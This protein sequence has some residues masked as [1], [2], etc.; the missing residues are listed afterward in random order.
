M[1][2]LNEGVDQDA[3]TFLS[4]LEKSLIHGTAVVVDTVEEVSAF[5]GELILQLRSAKH[6]SFG[7]DERAIPTDTASI[8]DEEPA[9]HVRAVFDRFQSAREGNELVVAFLVDA[10]EL[11]PDISDPALVPPHEEIP[12]HL[13]GSIAIRLDAERAQIGVKEEW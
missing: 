1:A 8:D 3:V 6:G 9:F 10:P 13:L 7:R 11:D 5:V 4:E 2:K 12:R